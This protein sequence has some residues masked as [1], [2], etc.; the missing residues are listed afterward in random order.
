MMARAF[1]LLAILAVSWPRTPFARQ[2]S[3]RVLQ[4]C[5]RTYQ[6]GVKLERAGKLIEAHKAMET[7]ATGV[8]GDFIAHQCAA[9]RDRLRSDTPSLVP[10]VTDEDG[11]T[12]TDVE[13]TMDEQVLVSAIDGRA[14]RVDPGMHELVFMRAGT[15][16]ATQ[17]IVAIQGRRNQPVAVQLQRD[18]PAVPTLKAESPA[19]QSKLPE[20]ALAEVPE[21]KPKRGSYLGSYLVMG[22]GLA[23]IAGYGVLT[24][25]GRGDNDQLA[26][27]TPNCLQ[28]SVDHI[29]DLYLAADISLGVGIA[30]VL[31]GGW[32]WWRNYSRMSVSVGPTYASIGGAF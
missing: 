32:M 28:S 7:C 31:T 18:K 9:G 29:H 26:K 20:A 19:P 30:A 13:V 25:W 27:C 17:K 11:E 15:I 4:A 22:S 3:R 21:E 5:E 16:I 12:V 8:C 2:P 23:A 10:I 6:R 24:Y 14:V 1:Q